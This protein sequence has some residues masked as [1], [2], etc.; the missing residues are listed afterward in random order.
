LFKRNQFCEGTSMTIQRVTL[1][2]LVAAMMMIAAMPVALTQ[3]NVP[4]PIA[5]RIPDGVQSPMAP[6]HV[7]QMDGSVKDDVDDIAASSAE[8]VTSVD[9]YVGGAMHFDGTSYA[10]VPIGIGTDDLPNMTFVAMVKSD[11]LPRDPEALAAVAASGY[12]YSDSSSFIV[13]SNQNKSSA[14]FYTQSGGA[15]VSQSTLHAAPQGVWHMVAMTRKIE[16][17]TTDDGEKLPHTILNLYVDGRMSESVNVFKPKAVP[18]TFFFGSTSAGNYSKLRGAIDQVGIYAR[19]LSKDELDT[20]RGQLRQAARGSSPPFAPT[21]AGRQGSPNRIPPDVTPAGGLPQQPPNSIDPREAQFPGDQFDS[22]QVNFP[23]DMFSEDGTGDEESFPG[24]MFDGDDEGDGEE[25]FPGDQLDPVSNDPRLAQSRLGERDP[26]DT[27]AL[28]SE[29][30]GQ[31]T[32]GSLSAEDERDRA[33]LDAISAQKGPRVSPP[34]SVDPNSQGADGFVAPDLISDNRAGVQ[35]RAGIDAV[36]IANPG[37]PNV[38][39][40][41]VSDL[42]TITDTEEGQDRLKAADWRLVGVV[43]RSKTEL[44]PGD[45]ITMT[46]RVKKDDPANKIPDVVLNVN[47][48]VRGMANAVLPFR[49]MTNDNKPTAT[50]D[51]PVTMNVPENL[52]F[53]DGANTVNWRLVARLTAKNG[54]DLV[55]SVPDNHLKE[56]FLRIKSPRETEGECVDVVENDDG[57]RTVG[58]CQHGENHVPSGGSG[59]YPPGYPNAYDNSSPD[60]SDFV[61]GSEFPR[62]DMSTRTVTEL[63]GFGF[64]N[65]ILQFESRGTVLGYI[66]TSEKGDVPC[67]IAIDDA[68]DRGGDPGQASDHCNGSSGDNKYFRIRKN[69]GITSLSTCG[70]TSKDSS[71]VKGISVG[72][73][74][75]LSDGSL[76]EG[77]DNSGFTRTNCN[78]NHW[79]PRVHCPIGYVATGIS[80]DGSNSSLAVNRGSVDSIG[81]I[82]GKPLPYS[83]IAW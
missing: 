4:N 14:Y 61:A 46:I 16:D 76:G 24:D 79:R 68:W 43:K 10:E 21:I 12:L 52:E 42:A 48:H 3:V 62:V 35:A 75:I 63:S 71:R 25:E 73:R 57:T 27:S 82:C 11:A 7:F 53:P 33:A 38:P 32:S 64:H 47:P 81:L 54:Y 78:N 80:F 69:W 13:L 83:P 15:L 6:I 55:D 49:V 22:D 65:K 23:G 50:M 44:Y 51:I 17:R 29:R 34:P 58:Q 28:S 2:R 18:P 41:R 30:L 40:D 59:M 37:A 31:W 36:S 19:A 8:N 5:D 20:M 74:P 72:I 66:K 70:A 67:R 77:L 26:L 39:N 60:N 45:E 56:I 9:G 1:P